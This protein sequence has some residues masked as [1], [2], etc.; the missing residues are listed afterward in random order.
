VPRSRK[1]EAIP[2]LPQYAF[3]VWCSV[4]RKK[5]RNY[6][7]FNL[8]YQIPFQTGFNVTDREMFSTEH[9]SEEVLMQYVYVYWLK[10]GGGVQ[11]CNI[12]KGPVRYVG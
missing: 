7:T 9:D 8:P 3:M 5:H 12:D 10:C 2:P 1:R 6:F 4:K 11:T